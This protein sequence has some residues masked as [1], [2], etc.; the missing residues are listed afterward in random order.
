M[1][2]SSL[3]NPLQ[4]ECCLQRYRL[5]L[6]YVHSL[7]LQFYKV[8]NIQNRLLLIVVVVP[9]NLPDAPLALLR[10]AG[11]L[12]PGGHGGGG[13]RL[14]V[15]GQVQPRHRVQEHGGGV[16]EDAPLAAAVVVRE[17]VVVVVVTLASW[18]G[19]FGS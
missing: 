13:G 7:C 2:K 17:G 16:E 18:V 3:E 8:V 12:G 14:E 15:P 19:K 11:P 6:L 9:D 10:V 5:P 1:S 4:Q